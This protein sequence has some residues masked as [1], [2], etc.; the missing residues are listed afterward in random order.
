M[1]FANMEEN[2]KA[3]DVHQC[4]EPWQSMSGGVGFF[5]IGLSISFFILAAIFSTTRVNNEGLVLPIVGLLITA[6][7]SMLVLQIYFRLRPNDTWTLNLP[8]NRK[9]FS[10]LTFEIQ[11]MLTEKEY[12][13]EMKSIS[14]E[15]YTTRIKEKLLPGIIPIKLEFPNAPSV[16][17][18]LENRIISSGRV[19]TGI[20]VANIRI[21][22]VRSENLFFIRLFVNDI[23]TILDDL[24]YKDYPEEE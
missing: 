13:Y 24:G 2:Y 4:P 21:K 1:E 14:D 12:H 16:S 23:M 15:L 20:K 19:G 8:Y 7:I 17:V 5:G 9:L 10:E 18:E 22:N 6:A 3:S 11:K